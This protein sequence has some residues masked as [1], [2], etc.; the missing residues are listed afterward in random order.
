MS[1]S[2]RRD[3]LIA[4]GLE[5]VG[6]RPLEQVSIDAIAEVAGVSRA[7][8]FHYFE[9]KQDFHVAIARAQAQE[10]LD[11]T[12]PDDSLGDPLLILGAS[13]SAFVD[14]VTENRTAYMAL[15]RG[16][17]SADPAMRAVTDQTRTV[18]VER[19]LERAGG[20]GI[21]STASVRLAV[22]G[23]IAFVEEVTIN[24]L[25][26]A[27]ISRAE[28]LTLITTSLPALAVRADG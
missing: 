21:E 16:S 28:L 5:M 6:N 13:M 20:L 18:M 19:I 17:A 7:L 11:C 22:A 15:I 10:M 3:Q 4:L 8:L 1:P 12:A 25:A 24:W 27:P 9:S 26:D 2:A 14:Y 23:W